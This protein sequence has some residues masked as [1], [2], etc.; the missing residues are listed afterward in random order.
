MPTKHEWDE[1]RL[2]VREAVSA[3]EKAGFEAYGFVLATRRAAQADP[4]GG[5]SCARSTRS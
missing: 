1:Q 5:A 2:L 4:A 3:F